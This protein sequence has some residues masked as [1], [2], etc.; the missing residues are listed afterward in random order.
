MRNV[1]KRQVYFHA[2]RIS[3]C[4]SSQA[5]G[6]A[7]K[8]IQ[9]WKMR[10]LLFSKSALASQPEGMEMNKLNGN[11]KYIGIAFVLVL[12]LVSIGCRPKESEDSLAKR[13]QE[14]KAREEEM[15]R[16]QLV[17]QMQNYADR[18]RKQLE[19]VLQRDKKK[20]VEIETDSR[21][22]G[23]VIKAIE[24]ENIREKKMGDG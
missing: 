10:F 21:R 18:K 4:I 13:R 16:E 7:T 5:F 8:K 12:L 22:F 3:V 20:L 14:E 24:D 11:G 6:D 17:A 23:E 1:W 2:W 9:D 19:Y 15:R